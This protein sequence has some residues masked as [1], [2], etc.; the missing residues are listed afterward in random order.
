MNTNTFIIL[1]GFFTI[2]IWYGSQ[3]T[4]IKRLETESKNLRAE[5]KQAINTEGT[6]NGKLWEKWY[7]LDRKISY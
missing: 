4:R 6:H 1:L 7:E 5:I 2:S 3:E